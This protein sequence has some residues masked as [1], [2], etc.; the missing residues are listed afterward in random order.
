MARSDTYVSPLPLMR[1]S[2]GLWAARTMAVAH[3]FGVFEHARA[4]SG[5][6]VAE[7]ANTA[8]STHARP[9]CC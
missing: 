1:I 2:S 9:S 7:F 4:G 6:T 3:E 5:V 8:G